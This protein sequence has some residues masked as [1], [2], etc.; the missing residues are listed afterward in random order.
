MSL[1]KY[2]V[3]KGEQF[4][5]GFGPRGVDQKLILTKVHVDRI[6]GCN[7]RVVV[8][9]DPSLERDSV[10][11]E[12]T[13][14]RIKKLFRIP[15]ELRS[16][17]DVQRATREVLR[18][19]HDSFATRV[20]FTLLGVGNMSVLM[21]DQ[22]VR[23]MMG[24]I[25]SLW[26]GSENTVPN[27]ILI[28]IYPKTLEDGDF[29]HTLKQHFFPYRPVENA[30]KGI[31]WKRAVGRWATRSFLQI[32]QDLSDS[33]KSLETTMGREAASDKIFQLAQKR[34]G[35]FKP[36]DVNRMSRFVSN[37]E[38]TNTLITLRSAGGPT[39]EAAR[40]ALIHHETEFA[41]DVARNEL[42]LILQA[43]KA[44]LAKAVA[45][46]RERFFETLS[47][48]SRAI[49]VDSMCIGENPGSVRCRYD[50]LW[51]RTGA[52]SW[53]DGEQTHRQFIRF[54][55]AKPLTRSR[56][57]NELFT[58]GMRV[59]DREEAEK[60]LTAIKDAVR[61]RY[62]HKANMGSHRL[63]G[64]QEWFLNLCAEYRDQLLG[65]DPDWFVGSLPEDIGRGTLYLHFQNHAESDWDS[66][67]ILRILVEEFGLNFVSPRDA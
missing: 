64:S 26:S 2:P 39:G 19:A 22:S 21:P 63:D 30:S 12:T 45:V 57:K 41:R 16:E 5:V 34:P 46:E 58:M 37:S 66:H 56:M 67:R 42:A 29:E 24:A 32:G 35:I 55:S 43:D 62:G 6:T 14:G 61:D 49:D 50:T 40:Q 10:I 23:A 44:E 13:E 4:R 18:Y 65:Q 15:W 17:D 60:I 11:S 8:D 31:G 9:P 51:R 1:P 20:A 52:I 27:Q 25:Y 47:L 33:L 38:I 54:H 7:G 53:N 59:A 28:S 36:A 48:D 3:L